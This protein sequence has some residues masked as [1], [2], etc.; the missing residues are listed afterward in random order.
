MIL[1]WL[2]LTTDF[3]SMNMEQIILKL[4]LTYAVNLFQGG[5]PTIEDQQL[6][7]ENVPV[8]VEKCIK[9]IEENGKIDFY[10]GIYL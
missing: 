5:G 9:F 10:G 1:N 3:R 6:T 7:P 2:F 4:D 8:I